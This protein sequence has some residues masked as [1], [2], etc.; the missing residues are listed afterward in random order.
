MVLPSS[1]MGQLS[2]DLCSC[3]TLEDG[4]SARRGVRAENGA[5]AGLP[6]SL[7]SLPYLSVFGGAC[8]APSAISSSSAAMRASMEGGVGK[9]K[10]MT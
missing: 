4:G 7:K 3:F 6:A 1:V 9:G 2:R 10:L 5:G 8:R